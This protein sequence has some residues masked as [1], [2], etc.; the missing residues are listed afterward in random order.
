MIASYLIISEPLVL[1]LLPN[2]IHSHNLFSCDIS[3]SNCQLKSEDGRP[4]VSCQT[5]LEFS[6]GPLCSQLPEGL[7]TY[8]GVRDYGTLGSVA[9]VPLS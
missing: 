3:D 2:L 6:G 7:C 9:A 4:S 5:S 1:N 8:G